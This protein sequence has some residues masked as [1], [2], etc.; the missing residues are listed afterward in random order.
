MKTIHII[1]HRGAMADRIENTMPSFCEALKQGATG[2]EMDIRRTA[3]GELVVFHD[4]DLQRLGGIPQRVEEM[5]LPD[6]QTVVLSQPQSEPQTGAIPTLHEVVT[7]PFIK[8]YLARGLVLSLEIKS[9][10]IEDLLVSSVYAWSLE[11]QVVIYSFHLEHLLK[12]Q[13]LAPELP[14]NLLFG[15]E[16]ERN[17]ERAAARAKLGHG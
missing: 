16:R 5:A 11:R 10:D 15:S 4:N 9:H 8:S 14:T 13:A 2:L 1:G 7:D 3:S 12:I 6:L 17:M